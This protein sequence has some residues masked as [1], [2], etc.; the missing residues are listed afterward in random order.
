M[1]E[2]TY[3]DPEAAAA[4]LRR[5]ADN[6]AYVEGLK[7]TLYQATELAATLA[8]RYVGSDVDDAREYFAELHREWDY[9]ESEADIMHEAVSALSWQMVGPNGSAAQRSVSQALTWASGVSNV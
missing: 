2:I 1:S 6:R 4:A 9:P 3:A 5:L 8:T 7:L